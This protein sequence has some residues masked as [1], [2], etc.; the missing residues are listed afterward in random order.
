MH[1]SGALAVKPCDAH[2]PP[3]LSHPKSLIRHPIPCLVWQKAGARDS[4]T[5]RQISVQQ[6]FV[7][8]SRF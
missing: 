6:S 8:A 1:G 3:E 7:T 4:W 2:T 5:F